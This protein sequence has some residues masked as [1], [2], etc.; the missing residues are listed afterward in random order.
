MK[1]K[2]EM[3][4]T[5]QM[6]EE[7]CSVT[8]SEDG[9]EAWMTL[10]KPE[11]HF[12][13]QEEILMQY[14][15]EMGVEQGILEEALQGALKG[16]EYQR[17]FL[18]AEG[19]PA[20]NGKNGC[21]EYFFDTDLQ[22]K[23]VE[24]EDGSVDYL[25]MKLFEVAE[26]GQLLACYHSATKGENGFTVRN[27]I[28]KGLDGKNLPPLKGSGFIYDRESQKYTA[29]IDGRIV[30]KHDNLKVDPLLIVD[31]VSYSTGNI[32]FRGDVLVKDCVRAGMLVEATG[33]VMVNGNVEGAAIYCGGNVLI[34]RGATADY[35]GSIRAKGNVSGRFFEGIVI[36]AG[37]S[38]YSDYYLNCNMHAKKN[39]IATGRKGSLAGGIA[40]ANQE[41]HVAKLGNKAGL[42]TVVSMFYENPSRKKEEYLEEMET[43][44]EEKEILIGEIDRFERE[45]QGEDLNSSLQY[46]RLQEQ[47]KE[48]K[49][50]ITETDEKWKRILEELRKNSGRVVV[51]GIAYDGCRVTFG[52]AEK[53]LK[54]A[55]RELQ[56]RRI[57]NEVVTESLE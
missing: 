34:K 27:Q 23:P 51:D 56:F 2:K 17:P 50:K 30:F 13:Y 8:I 21:Y 20:E 26:E 35:K 38:I 47:L 11:K 1:K 45:F 43:L 46:A 41:V 54:E 53:Y 49:K 55:Q 25:N 18:V 10:E 6:L 48:Q 4:I 5:I 3:E 15:Q 24:K 32:R 40:R 57:G 28:I 37:D 36:D 29:K 33:D 42:N 22:A 31:E 44:Q 52:K 39:I 19:K 7:L 16:K 14:L 9:M 12:R